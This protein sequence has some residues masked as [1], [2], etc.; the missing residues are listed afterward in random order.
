MCVVYR[1]G[2]YTSHGWRGIGRE[3]ISFI[4]RTL[5]L[6]PLCGSCDIA[7]IFKGSERE[8]LLRFGFEGAEKTGVA[9]TLEGAVA[10][11]GARKEVL[12]EYEITFRA[13]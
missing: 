1:A 3:M 9:R 7:A 12:A 5:A 4:Y 2:V 6:S 8:K 11:K 10:L 13:E